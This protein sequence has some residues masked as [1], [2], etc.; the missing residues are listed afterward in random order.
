MFRGLL[1]RIRDIKLSLRMKMTLSF[2]AI[3][4]VLLISSVISIMEYR[5]MSHYLSSLIADNINSINVAQGIAQAADTYNLKVLEAVADEDITNLPEFDQEQFIASCEVLKGSMTTQA[6]SPLA[7]SVLYAYPA[8]LLTTME[9]SDVVLSDFIDSRTWFVERLQ[10]QFIRLQ[11]Y[12]D[13]LTDAIYG[14]LK[15]N[16]ETFDRGFY[17][18]IIPGAV[19]VGVGILLVVLLLLFISIY[20]ITP[21]YKML[22]GLDNYRSFNRKYHYTFDGDDQLVA[23]NEGVTDL[24]EENRQLKQQVKALKEARKK[25]SEP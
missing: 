6:L 20:Y 22:A 10:P 19:A 4:V 14:D 3:V 15:H 13:A 1:N 2:S 25:P 5:R 21:L 7:D 11:A 16:S 9:V 18:S 23:L 17:R 8:Y 12:I 24:I